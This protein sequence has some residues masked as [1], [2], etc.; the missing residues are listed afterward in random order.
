M[1]GALDTVVTTD[2]E[3]ELATILATTQKLP[4][5]KL[6][7]YIAVLRERIVVNTTPA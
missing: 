5:E 4:I 2:V 1:A 6:L 7:V 3:T